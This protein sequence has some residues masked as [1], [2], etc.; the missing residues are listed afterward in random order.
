MRMGLNVLRCRLDII[1]RDKKKMV[2][3]HKTKNK[4]QNK[5]ECLD[6]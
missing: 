1:I 6:Q 5:N 3:V 4:K 2:L